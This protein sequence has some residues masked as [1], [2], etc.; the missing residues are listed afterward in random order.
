MKTQAKAANTVTITEEE[1]NDLISLNVKQT[2]K[3]EGLS[4]LITALKKELEIVKDSNESM[5]EKLINIAKK[6][7]LNQLQL[8][9][10]GKAK[11]NQLAKLEKETI[12]IAYGNPN[13]FTDSVVAAYLNFTKSQLEWVS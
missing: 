11:E 6:Y 4:D 9:F 7:N 8:S 2:S 1:F 10:L 3:V 13:K 5:N 12:N